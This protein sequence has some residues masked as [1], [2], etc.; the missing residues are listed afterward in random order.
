MKGLLA[1]VG[2]LAGALAPGPRAQQ[3]FV[4]HAAYAY[5]GGGQRGATAD[6]VIGGQYLQGPTAAYVSGE[7][8][9]VVVGE[10]HKP[11]TQGQAQALQQKLRDARDKLI[12]DGVRVGPLNNPVA[13]VRIAKEAGISDEELRDVAEFARERNDPKRQPNAQ[14]AET[15][16]VQVRVAPGAAPGTREIRLLSTWGL[17]NPVRFEIGSLA[18][19]VAEPG[20]QELGNLPVTVNGRILPGVADRYGLALR[21]GQRIVVSANVRGLI[22]FIADAVPGWFQ[23]A[24]SLRDAK[25]VEVAFSDHNATQQDP[26]LYFAVPQDGGYTLEVRDAIYRGRE[27]FVYRVTIGEVAFVTSIFPLGGRAQQHT[28]VEALGWNLPSAKSNV[29][30]TAQGPGTMRLLL[31]GC[32]IPFALDTLPE[33]LQKEPNDD[34][35]RA[36]SLD[37]PVIVN[38]RIDRPGD[39]D[40]VRIKGRAGEKVVAEVEAR[41]LGSPLDSTLQLSDSKG[42][43]LA[44]NDDFLDPG[45]PMVTHQADSYLATALPADGTYFVTVRDAQGQGGTAF[46]YRLRISAPRPD[47]E[48][49]VVPSSVTARPGTTVMLTV[50]VLRRDGFAGDIA[51]ALAGTPGEYHLSGGVIPGQVD[52]LPITLTVPARSASGPVQLQIEGVGTV[53]GKPVRRVATPAEDMM[54]A[55]GYRHLV[56]Q[57]ALLVAVLGRGNPGLEIT[58]PETPVKVPLGGTV[59]LR[60]TV[61]AP[62][63]ANGLRFAIGDAPEGLT[64]QSAVADAKGVTLVL[65]ADAQKLKAGLRGNL[66]LDASIQPP[67][68]RANGNQPARPAAQRRASIGQVPAIPFEIVG[69]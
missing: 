11:L 58:P 50:H 8:V 25:G 45:V 60:L 32:G 28:A 34:S 63:L 15:V 61:S 1:C 31:A 46:G 54:Q 10:Y 30:G 7:G 43:V 65:R 53:L 66:I 69:K 27:D 13:L 2:V 21:K 19:V 17:S 48:L 68:Q 62:L 67:A 44:W 51:L 52:R 12:K 64:L 29:D 14:I 20:G 56:P 41:R 38:G 59:Q 40:V 42:K 16:R 23:A 49:R 47:F 24:L 36:Q 3:P 26:V 37:H 55:F 18:E 39:V 4:P 22:P 57:D 5:P 9:E 35:A 6:V 33:T